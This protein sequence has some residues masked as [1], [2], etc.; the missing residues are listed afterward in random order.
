MA[1]MREALREAMDDQLAAEEQCEELKAELAEWERQ[2]NPRVQEMMAARNE[3][4][5]MNEQ[6][7]LAEERIMKAEAAREQADMELIVL[8]QQVAAQSLASTPS[9]DRRPRMGSS[10][11]SRS[12]SPGAR[13]VDA[14]P[15]RQQSQ[16]QEDLARELGDAEREIWRLKE[17]MEQ[18]ETQRLTT[19]DQVDELK[20]RMADMQV[21]ER[22]CMPLWVHAR[23]CVCVCVCVDVQEGA[24]RIDVPV[25]HAAACGQNAFDA[26]RQAAGGVVEGCWR[27]PLPGGC[28]PGRGNF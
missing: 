7:Q 26:G 22:T 21:A 12:S 24:E 10:A 4:K 8:R 11:R 17:V 5:K 6:L 27:F 25:P 23:V 15:T 28:T 9:A 16:G 2:H 20:G 13:A 18:L 19:E 14:P 1:E 3:L